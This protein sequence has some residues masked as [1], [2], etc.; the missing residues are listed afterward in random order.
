LLTA[1]LCLNFAVG[2]AQQTTEKFIPIGMSPGVS[3]ISS[4]LGSI[5]SVDPAAKSFSMQTDGD[6]KIISVAPTTRIWLDR[7]ASRKSNL[8][9]EFGALEAGSRVEIM[10]DPGDP[11]K[12]AW[13]KIEAE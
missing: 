10:M 12:A 2:R 1:L 5:T 7:S 11:T 3:G 9:G 13:I 6:S 4:Y 8:D